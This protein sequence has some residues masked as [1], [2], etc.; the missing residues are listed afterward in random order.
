[1]QIPDSIGVTQKAVAD[2]LGINKGAISREV[3][4]GDQGVFKG[5]IVA[6]TSRLVSVEAAVAAWRANKDYTDAPQHAQGGAN[7]TS[8]AP[9]MVEAAVAAKFWDA[10]L[11]ELKY[12]EAA[13]EL[14]KAS[15]VKAKLADVFSVCRTRLL[16]IP[17]RARQVLPHLT[18]S[19]L[20]TIEGLVREALEDLSEGGGA[21]AELEAD[22]GEDG[23]RQIPDS[24][25]E[26]Q[27]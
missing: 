21:A 27:P 3:S 25:T 26:K 18:L 14:V 11:K 20:A 13:G 15:E 8:D 12:R 24:D 4:K 19:D 6:G 10:R 7:G 1:M 5:L 16:A 2:V 22:D 17:S 9:T 23:L